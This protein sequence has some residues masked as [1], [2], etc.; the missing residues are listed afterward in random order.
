MTGESSRC[1]AP[2]VGS[3]GRQLTARAHGS[4]QAADRRGQQEWRV[5]PD[6]AI[7]RAVHGLHVRR[8]RLLGG[9]PLGGGKRDIEAWETVRCVYIVG[10]IGKRVLWLKFFGFAVEDVIY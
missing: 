3:G 1:G 8:N 2:V 4:V 10:G 6:Q 7:G 9:I 5:R